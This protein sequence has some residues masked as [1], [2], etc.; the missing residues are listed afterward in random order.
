MIVSAARL[1]G[2]AS[3]HRRVYRRGG[4]I[5]NQP[6]MTSARGP[7]KPDRDLA[8]DTFPSET[9]M[10]LH[11]PRGHLS[12]Q[13]FQAVQRV[14]AGFRDLDA[15]DDKVLAKEIVMHGAVME[16]LRRQHRREH[17]NLGL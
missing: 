6:I 5:D 10:I 1:H 11:N 4:G 12:A 17:R 7:A 13:P 8:F 14:G 16:L 15:F 3:S 9:V 2:R